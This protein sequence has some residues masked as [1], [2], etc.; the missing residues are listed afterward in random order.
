MQGFRHDISKSARELMHSRVASMKIGVVIPCFRVR[1]HIVDVVRGVL[2]QADR[3]Y[4]VDDCCPENSG[5][6]VSAVVQSPKLTVIMNDT[7]QG[8]GGAVAIG[9]RRALEEGCEII[10][11]LDGDGQMDSRLLPALIQ[12]IVDGA[13]DYTKGNRFF[14][15]DHLSSMP[16]VR[17]FGNSILS[18]VNKASCGYWNVMDP[19]NGFT[20]IHVAALHWIP[21]NKL[22][23]GYFFESDM[24]FRLGTIR[25]VVEDV[26]MPALYGHEIS[27]LKIGHT[28]LDFPLRYLV[29][30]FKRF[31]YNY[32][33]RDVNVGTVETI[34]GAACLAFGTIF[35]AIKWLQVA[36]IGQGAPAGTIMLA[37]LP[38]ILGV[39]FLLAALS[40]DIA[41]VPREP[42]QKHW[43]AETR[44]LAPR[45]SMIGTA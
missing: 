40:F 20:A 18:L 3:V 4:V 22:S 43:S 14:D 29:N 6:E 2:S 1:R 37:A 21:L 38:V 5:R 45:M 25:A 24:L 35:G 19:T 30:F 23:R 39:Q 13:A 9:Y 26:P 17:L 33:I 44:R 42:L 34:V 27:N 16:H 32:V 11:K 7:N 15:M 10:V 31:F 8:V 41:N 36:A 12:P 28:I